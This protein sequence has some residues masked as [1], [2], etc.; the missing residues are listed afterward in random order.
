[1]IQEDSD[2]AVPYCVA[3]GNAE[4]LVKFF[5]SH[6]QLTD[7]MMSAVAAYE[8]AIAPPEG[9]RKRSKRGSSV[10]GVEGDT[11]ENLR[12]VYYSH[13]ILLHFHCLLLTLDW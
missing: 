12:L 3:S 11:E 2:E 6:G 1:M 8:G 5:T 9:M 4:S 10:N 7:A 13:C